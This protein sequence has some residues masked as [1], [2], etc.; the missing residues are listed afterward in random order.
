M[1]FHNQGRVY[2]VGLFGFVEI[3]DLVFGTRTSLVLDPAEEQL[4][5]EFT[6]VGRS[7]IPMH[8]IIRIDEVEKEGPVKVTP[9]KGDGGG[10][11]MPFPAYTQ[12]DPGK[13]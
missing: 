2:E 4:K 5:S 11:V 9:I 6:G 1:I 3:G 10:N 7:Y 12:K 8:A 13:S